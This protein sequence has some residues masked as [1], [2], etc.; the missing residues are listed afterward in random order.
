MRRLLVPAVI[1]VL[2][3]AGCD[4]GTAPV[5][6]PATP[7]AAAPVTSASATAPEVVLGDY[8][9]AADAESDIDKAL[10]AA[11]KSGRNVLIDFGADWCLDCRVLTELSR[12]PALNARLAEGFEVVSVD[13]GEFDRNLEVAEHYGLDLSRSGVPALV[14]VT[15]AGKVRVATNDGA[16]SEARSMSAGDVGKFLARWAPA[17]K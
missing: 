3:M 5:A 7:S 13:V 10:A 4:D 12:T 11:K 6:A 16:F 17:G 2:A 1:A 9:P 14:V 8:D 15:P